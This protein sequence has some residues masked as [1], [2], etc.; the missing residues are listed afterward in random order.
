MNESS[1]P[2]SVRSIWIRLLY[3]LLFMM[4]FGLAEF[5][6]YLTAAIGFVYRL[7]GQPINKRVC[8]I[9]HLIGLYI[10]QIS[11][12]L[13]FNTEQAPFPF[14]TWPEDTH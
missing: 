8:H 13:S 7:F 5:A 9:G 12:F 11:D 1:E 14:D 10:R 3:M 2:E 4:I 6:V